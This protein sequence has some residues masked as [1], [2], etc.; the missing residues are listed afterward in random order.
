MGATKVKKDKKKSTKAK[1]QEALDMK[2]KDAQISKNDPTVVADFSR[3]DSAS[4]NDGSRREMM[5]QGDTVRADDDERRG[6]V[7]NNRF[8]VNDGGEADLP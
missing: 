3:E 4:E 6:P 1:R 2:A 5:N 7:G 8:D